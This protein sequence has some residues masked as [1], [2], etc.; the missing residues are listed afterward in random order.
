MP[1]CAIPKC[2]C[3]SVPRIAFTCGCSAKISVLN[4]TIL[5]YFFP[6]SFLIY[7]F[8]YPFQEYLLYIALIYSLH[9]YFKG[10][11]NLMSLVNS[12]SSYITKI[13]SFIRLFPEIVYFTEFFTFS[14]NLNLAAATFFETY[15]VKLK[16]SH[17]SSLL[18]IWTLLILIFLLFGLHVLVCCSII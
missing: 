3:K 14:L 10:S 5:T 9:V 7:K 2:G 13:P 8:F 17:H 6:L 4:R 16:V 1:L 11:L 18:K 15:E 12:L